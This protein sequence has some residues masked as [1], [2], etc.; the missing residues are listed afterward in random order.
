M[1]T[2]LILMFGRLGAV[3]GSNFVGL[4]LDI[5]CELIFYL[6][7]AMILS[8]YVW[9]SATVADDHCFHIF[10]VFFLIST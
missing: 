10:I 2:C 1:A 3:G 8:E 5:N 4:L 6:Y 9:L 7:G